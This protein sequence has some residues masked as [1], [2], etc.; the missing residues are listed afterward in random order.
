MLERVFD[1]P[2]TF[3]PQILPTP[4]HS[5]PQRYW[6]AYHAEIPIKPKKNPLNIG[7]EWI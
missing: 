2:P 6:L 4:A 5:C 7:L 1:E 3:L